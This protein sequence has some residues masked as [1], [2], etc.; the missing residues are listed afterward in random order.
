MA[1]STCSATAGCPP[2]QTP[3][4]TF[5]DDLCMGLCAP[6]SLSSMT[7]APIPRW[8]SV[9]TPQTVVAAPG[10]R[11]ARQR[12]SG[13]NSR[14]AL[15]AARVSAPTE[16]THSATRGLGLLV[17]LKCDGECERRQ[18]A[19]RSFSAQR[20]QK[21]LW[22]I[23][24]NGTPDGPPVFLTCVVLLLLILNGIIALRR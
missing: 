8:A 14:V 18:R 23:Q 2:D 3:G 16:C 10:Q 24:D 6:P 11:L 4:G 21:F 15:R 22:P 1:F 17:T 5:A 7:V 20:F 12:G 13:V 9:K 19:A